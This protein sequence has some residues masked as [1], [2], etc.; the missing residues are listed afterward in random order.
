[1][2]GAILIGAAS[3]ARRIK[4]AAIARRT[5]CVHLSNFSVSIHLIAMDLAGG[6]IFKLMLNEGVYNQNAFIIHENVEL[7]LLT[8]A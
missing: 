2:P 1:L 5:C 4:E 6:M 8:R 7:L 3:D